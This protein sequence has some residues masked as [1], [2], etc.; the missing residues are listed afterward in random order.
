MSYARLDSSKQALILAALCEGSAIN[1]VC[2]MFKV[3]KQSVMRVI[4][5]TGKACEDWHNRRFRDLHNVR[6][7]ELDE[8]GA[9]VQGATLAEPA[10]RRL[11]AV[12]EH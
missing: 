4:E 6:R 1:S 12:S 2:R 11:L 8:Q 9:H 3:G 5:E 10:T 7:L